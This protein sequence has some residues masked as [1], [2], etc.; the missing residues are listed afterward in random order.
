MDSDRWKQIDKL[1]HSVLERPPEERDAFL[2]IACAGDEGLER[3]AR[4]LLS[5]EPNAE[6]FLETPAIQMA[7][8]ASPAAGRGAH[9]G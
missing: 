1:L 6:G 8:Q 9:A 7:A 3:E 2:Q 5:L 4:S